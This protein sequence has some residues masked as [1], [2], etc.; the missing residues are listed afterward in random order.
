MSS[1]ECD[2]KAIS[3]FEAGESKDIA[4]PPI[5]K[6]EDGLKWRSFLAAIL[7]K[8]KVVELYNENKCFITYCGNLWC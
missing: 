1:T 2:Y 7:G 4:Q 3:A 5:Y 6:M 8:W